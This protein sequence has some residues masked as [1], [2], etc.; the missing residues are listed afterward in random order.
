M[1]F[2]LVCSPA[3]AIALKPA[4][5]AGY[6]FDRVEAALKER[7]GDT[8][9]LLDTIGMSDAERWAIYSDRAVSAAGS[10]Y[11]ISRVFGSNTHG[12]DYFGTDVP[13]LLA[14]ANQ[15][16]PYPVDVWPHEVGGGRIVT[17][18]AYLGL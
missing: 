6:R 11:R 8:Y 18:A 2:Q 7:D 3:R 12:G 1:H 5:N 9:E 13:A 10:R 16:D 15:G 17:M 14:Y 4:E